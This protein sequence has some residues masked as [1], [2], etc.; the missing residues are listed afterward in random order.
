MLLRGWWEIIAG[1]NHSPQELPFTVTITV[2]SSGKVSQVKH[3]HK[4][5]VIWV[6]V[7]KHTQAQTHTITL[8]SLK[9][10]NFV[11]VTSSAPGCSLGSSTCKEHTVTQSWQ[12]PLATGRTPQGGHY[13]SDERD[14]DSTTHSQVTIGPL[15][16]RRWFIWEQFRFK[17]SQKTP[18]SWF[19]VW[20]L[21]SELW[22]V[23][24]AV[25]TFSIFQVSLHTLRSNHTCK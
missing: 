1:H 21:S 9:C 16:P 11:T 25:F 8:T 7:N 13:S 3:D 15:I 24:V 18:F 19:F 10:V 14:G 5:F 22:R 2:T 12:I 6:R 20:Q 4:Q 17:W 23:D